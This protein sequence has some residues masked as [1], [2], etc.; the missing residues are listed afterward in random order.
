MKF[1]QQGF[2]SDVL[3]ILKAYNTWSALPDNWERGRFCEEFFLSRQTLYAMQQVQ[4]Q[5]ALCLYRSGVLQISAGPT[6]VVLH[7]N[8]TGR[9]LVPSLFNINGES[10]PLLT[11]LM[12][13]ALAPN[14]AVRRTAR[15]LRSPQDPVRQSVL[16]VDRPWLM[17]R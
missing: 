12:S 5:L 13:S 15:L 7:R 10:L 3:T 2:R 16:V 8:R 17:E 14:F 11:A 1:S 9:I 6:P 4:D